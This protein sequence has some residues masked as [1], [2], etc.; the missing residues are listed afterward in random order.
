MS[1][2]ENLRRTID[3]FYNGRILNAVGALFV[4]YASKL[5]LDACVLGSTECWAI[6]AALGICFYFKPQMSII[7][8]AIAL[9]FSVMHISGFMVIVL[10]VITLIVITQAHPTAWALFMLPLAFIPGSPF[11]SAGFAIL[12]FGICM[13]RISQ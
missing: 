5:L 6:A 1:A 13:Y 10:T 2:I 12:F 3:N 9:F 8:Y 11:L 4:I 7:L